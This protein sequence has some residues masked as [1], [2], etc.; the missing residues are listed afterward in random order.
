MEALFNQ[1]ADEMRSFYKQRRC[2]CK[3]I[4]ERCWDITGKEV[5]VGLANHREW[6]MHW[7]AFLLAGQL[8]C[9]LVFFVFILFL[10]FWRV[11]SSL[12][13]CCRRTCDA[14]T[15]VFVLC[16]TGDNARVGYGRALHR[17]DWLG[18]SSHLSTEK[19]LKT[20][21]LDTGMEWKNNEPTYIDLWVLALR[22]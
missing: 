4:W 19:L 5:Y 15:V 22:K 9:G 12:P 11:F 3:W 14:V 16:V 17:C 7:V 1:N 21:K 20:P 8:D 10:C 18:A 6:A 2:F 13:T